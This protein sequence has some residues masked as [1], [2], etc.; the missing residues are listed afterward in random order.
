MHVRT[1]RNPALGYTKGD[2]NE[3]YRKSAVNFFGVFIA[4]AYIPNQFGLIRI[5]GLGLRPIGFTINILY[6][7][8]CMRGPTIYHLFHDDNV[9]T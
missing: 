1:Q 8:K 9:Q 3:C 6:R 5:I 2:S 4:Y 7:P